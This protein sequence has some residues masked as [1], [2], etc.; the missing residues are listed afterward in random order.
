MLKSFSL[1][2]TMISSLLSSDKLYHN[3]RISKSFS[4]VECDPSM[5]W[6]SFDNIPAAACIFTTT[7]S[8][9]VLQATSQTTSFQTPMVLQ[10]RPTSSKEQ[11]ISSRQTP[12]LQ[13]QAISQTPRLLQPRPTSSQQQPTATPLQVPPTTYQSPVSC[14]Q[15]QYPCFRSPNF[16]QF[17][18]YLS[19][20]CP[21]QTSTCFG[22]GQPL[23]D[24]TQIRMAPNDMV[25]VSKM[26]R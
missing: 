4:T 11:P 17:L 3:I 20:F 2:P 14:P 23:K 7:T 16:G 22:C 19:Q 26:T 12:A 6:S 21:R 24:G 8:L 25:I 15:P 13:F 9:L 10:Q 18:I 5:R 1:P